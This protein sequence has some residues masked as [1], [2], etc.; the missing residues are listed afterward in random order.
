MDQG[1]GESQCPVTGISV[2]AVLAGICLA[3]KPLEL[4]ITQHPILSPVYS[5]AAI[6]ELMCLNLVLTASYKEL[7]KSLFD[8]DVPKQYPCLLGI[9]SSALMGEKALSSKKFLF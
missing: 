2:W 7:Y 4:L 3:S 1:E 9:H 6:Y 8:L 5:N